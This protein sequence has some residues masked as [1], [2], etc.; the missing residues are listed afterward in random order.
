LT[1]IHPP[2]VAFS[3][4]STLLS[5]TR[6]SEL[7]W[8][9]PGYTFYID[10]RV[11]ELE[12]YDTILGYDWLKKH[13]PM[14]CHWDLKTMEFQ[15][16]GQH[17]HLQGIQHEQ[18]SLDVMSPEQFVKCY[19]GNDIWALTVVQTVSTSPIEEVPHAIDQVLQEFPD[20]FEDPNE[21]PTHRAYDH[22]IPLL[23][24]YFSQQHTISLFSPTQR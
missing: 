14:A 11:L 24:V 16:R 4:P 18:L 19:I 12:A 5:N 1:S 22:S 2:L 10:M 17:V 23:L 7:E 20:V 9:A 3:G 8:W 6:V 15:E 21:L 13:N